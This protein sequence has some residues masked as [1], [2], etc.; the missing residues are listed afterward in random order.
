MQGITRRALVAVAGA[1]TFVLAAALP[2]GAASLYTGPGSRPG[3]D[4][5]YERPA[6]DTAPQLTNAGI[7]KAPPILVS[8]A[9]AYRDG[10][11]LYQDFLYDDHGANGGQRDSGDPRASGGTSSD[12]FSAPNGTYTYPTDTKA[13][14]NNAADLVELRVRPT[15]ADT[16]FRLT[17]NSLPDP[18]RVG[19]TIAIGDAAAPVPVPFGANATAAAQLFLTVHGTT[20]DLRDAAGLA[21][22]T[23]PV[24]VALDTARRQ[25]DVR[26]PHADWNPG[27]G[28][29]KLSAGVGLWDQAADRYLIPQHDA[30]ATHPGGA[31]TL[32]APPAFFNV[33]FRTQE[34]DKVD[35]SKP[36][37]L[38][39]PVWWRDQQQGRRLA[40]GDLGS[41]A[42]K[43]DFAKLAAG[44]GDDSGVPSTGGFDRIM[45][46]HA[47]TAQGADYS[48]TCGSSAKCLGELRG[49]LQPYAVYVPK[50]PRPAGGWPL[51]LLLH[52]L[53]AN[54]NQFLNTNN[55]HQFGDRG[56]GSIVITAEGRGTDGWYYDHAGADTFE[57]WADAAQRYPLA[58]DHT[59]I[60]GYSMGGYA[61]WKL[62]TQFPDLFAKAQPT[63]G[64]AGLGVWVPPGDPQPGGAQSNTNRM[65]ASVRNVPFLIWNASADELV[66]TPGAVQQAQTLDDL[67]YRYVFD[68]FAPAEHLTL[69]LDDQYAPAADFLG[70]P[71]VDRNPSHVT[72][73]VNPTM[74]FPALHTVADHAYWA[75]GL[76]LR[77]GSGTA[78][79]GTIDAR[80]HGFGTGDPV[81]AATQHGG[82]AL[83]GGNVP[84]IAYAETSRAWG[85]APAEPVR[86]ALDVTLKNLSTASV[87]LARA[88]LSCDATITLKTDGPAT[89]DLPGCDR[90]VR[91]AAAGTVTSAGTLPSSRRCVSRRAFTIHLRLPKGTVVRSARLTIN[92]HRV[93]HLR[94]RRGVVDLRGLP[95]GRF[96]VRIVASV[97]RHGKTTTITDTRRYRTC[98]AK[99]R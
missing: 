64:P 3:P 73:V 97:R 2:A 54:Y 72:Y 16:A 82:G 29:V 70:D 27:T 39:D 98:T 6:T 33:A 59:T 53:G 11:F 69:A 10:E 91:A 55:Q 75:S 99:R 71:A 26:I 45:A 84:A 21:V 41:F 58:A 65:L 78:P 18:A 66:P 61:T 79:L 74:D 22:G 5:L 32:A 62:T 47:E 35:T 37:V 44:T 13:Y 52:S 31:G 92:G 88:K 30:D 87:D 83:T 49:R 19:F 38:T 60:A 7:W 15:A 80:S 68:L 85:A 90:S 40:T 95:A 50:K 57:M 94:R 12:D 89:L 23:V 96:T 63:V 77:D 17:L 93:R 25:Y 8:G 51:T 14:V 34:P 28:V 24:T 67:G 46:S 42:A 56:P 36:D 1:T 86:D 48:Q 4:L 20:A 76:H 43:V 81:P 9:T